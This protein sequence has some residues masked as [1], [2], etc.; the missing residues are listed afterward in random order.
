MP[1][2]A[3]NKKNRLAC[4]RRFNHIL[5]GMLYLLT[6]YNLKNIPADRSNMTVGTW[7]LIPPEAPPVP[8][9]R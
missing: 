5:K 2:L 8:T 1:S 4:A 3:V 9:P 7:K 6:A